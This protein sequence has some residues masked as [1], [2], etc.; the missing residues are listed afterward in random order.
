MTSW[1]GF[2]VS[3]ARA[4]W[5][6]LLTLLALVTVT[7]GIIAGTVGYSQ[8]AAT[9]AARGALTQGE[10][11]EAG[12]QVE[13]R[14]DVDDPDR[15]D[16]LAREAITE[17]FAPAPVTVGRLVVSE[18]RPVQTGGEA[19]DG[20]LVLLGSPDLAAGA[21]DLV[22][23]V[24]VVEGSWP[25]AGAGGE[26]AGSGA[27]GDG[28][29][30]D[31]T[32]DTVGTDGGDAPAQ[33]ALH[34]GAATAWGV[35][36][37]DVLTFDDR[38]VEITATWTP[39]DAQAAFWFGAELVRAGQ[40]ES[41]HGPLVVD[42]DLVRQVGSPFVRWPVQPDPDT[43]SP[44]DLAGLAS[45]A[46][47]LR[48]DLRDVEGVSIRGI[49]VDGDLAPTAATA[50]TN[51][52]TARAL[53]VIPLSV[54][55]LVT[56]L[57]VVQLAR[58]LAATREPQVQLLVARGA[59]RPQVTTVGLVES[60]VVAVVGAAL[61]GILAWAVMQ[62][63]PGGELVGGTVLTVS[64]LV[65]LGILL[66]LAAVAVGQARRLAGGSAASDRSGRARAATA[67]ATVVLVL[68]AAALSWWQ[69]RRAGSPLVTRGDGS[70]GTD[71]VAGAAPALLLAAAAVVALALLG[72]LTRAVEL[73]TRPS[74]TAGGHLAS[75]Q[76]SRHL[77]VYAV[78]VVLTVLAVGATTLASLYAG[79]SAQLRDDLAAVSQGAPLRAD[80]VR[81][82]FEEGPGQ[83]PP[84]AAPDLS[85]L[86]EIE[87]STLVWLEP[88]ARI[89]DAQVPLT[90]ADTD[91][92]PAVTP[93]VAGA[94]L[95]PEGLD[96]LV[97]AEGRPLESAAGGGV[98]IPEGTGALTAELSVELDADRWEIARLDGLAQS[99]RDLHEQIAE[100]GVDAEDGI[101]MLPGVG[102]PGMFTGSEEDIAD[103]LEQ[104]V[105]DAARGQALYV[106][107][108]VRDTTTGQT[109]TLRSESLSAAGPT[110]T[111]DDETLTGFT[112]EPQVTQGELMIPLDPE[113]TWA[114][115]SLT[116]GF[117]G[118]EE[119]FFGGSAQ[120]ALTLDLTLRA[121]S[122]DLL[123]GTDG[124]GSTAAATPEQAAPAVEEAAAV[125]DP[126]VRDSYEI[127][128]GTNSWGM[129]TS[130]ESNRVQVPTV[131][132]TS[133]ATWH[134][135]GSSTS[136]PDEA[137]VGQ[138]GMLPAEMTVAPGLTWVQNP[139]MPTGGA[140]D[141]EPP[142][143]V[144]VPV[145]L[146]RA[147]ADAAALS[148]GDAFDIA[149]AGAALPGV[150]ST[151]VEAVPG[152]TGELAAL[153]DSRVL[154]RALAAD[155]RTMDRP[156]QVWATPADPES[157]DAALAALTQREDLRAV[158]GPGAVSVA[159]ATSAARLVFWVASAGAVLLALTGIAAVAATLLS[160][161]RPEVAVL[162]ALGMPPAAQA[163]SR[164]L[165]LGG[166][167]LAAVAFGLGAGWLV[168][169][170][171]VPELASSTIRPGGLTLPAQLR[172]EVAP[173]A[174]L[175]GAGAVLV[176][177]LTLVLASRVRAQAL[178]RDYRE[179]IR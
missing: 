19:L 123:T 1:S 120:L 153:A 34:V 58:L 48:D 169:S 121:G 146:T 81:P 6:L 9:T 159:D 162:R 177:G 56:G 79:T 111:F 173:W 158:T 96:Q 36:V 175:V 128:S 68:G 52:A 76:V 89:G 119:A 59:S 4:S 130:T 49:A 64:G 103:G 7:T 148:V 8:A 138:P 179:E 176:L 166:V 106:G 102:M 65:L 145:A 85:T 20:R 55:V 31:A 131:L 112:A 98:L 33:G 140:P 72:P 165:E 107:A 57:A 151:V 21:E 78:P 163:R 99:Q 95:V 16:Q 129:S 39:V 149:Y 70:L 12:V 83:P 53:G 2:A 61:G 134:V 5:G 18:P 108:L 41:D 24:T 60:V 26:E 62:L 139:G 47:E 17:A 114:L 94:S 126:Y 40:V 74:R 167:V 168:G 172:L 71:L 161:R 141:A 77:S 109:Y 178:D 86:P 10:P 75:A 90:L 157:A 44:D 46:E 164:A 84:P 147:A 25:E 137:R 45:S 144:R 42:E 127:H 171:V 101:A 132:D 22:E 122:Q 110:L 155:E 66:V 92:L 174:V 80:V 32:G 118:E 97:N 30:A 88:N 125:E 29:Q 104:E 35:G 135:E 100:L 117:P 154:A 51:L 170:A 142:A 50:A 91:A 3:R 23:R 73:G 87:D 14:L 69:L 93:V 37:G 13:T 63:V 105:L 67:L 82:P 156:T 38:A 152:Q 133:S 11:T 113:R 124:W 150:L 136:W 15:Q 116:L 27:G 160:S 143:T 115:E 54:L 28:S 43:I